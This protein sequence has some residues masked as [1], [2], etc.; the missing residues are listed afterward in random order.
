MLSTVSGSSTKYWNIKMKITATTAM[1]ANNK[2][3]ILTVFTL[4]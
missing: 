4:I 3:N 1:V 2:L